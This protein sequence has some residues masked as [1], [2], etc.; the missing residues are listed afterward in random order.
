MDENIEF[1]LPEDLSGLTD[2]ALE[3]LR[4]D[5]TACFTRL[6]EAEATNKVV[7]AMTDLAVSI[8]KIKAEQTARSTEIAENEARQ[9]K[10]VAEVNGESDE[11]VEGDEVDGEPEGDEDDEDDDEVEDGDGDE[12]VTASATRRRHDPVD[13]LP[14]VRKIN[15]SLSEIRKRQPQ[16]EVPGVESDSLTVTASADIPQVAAGSRIED[17]PS[18]ANAIYQ[19]AKGLPITTGNE[20]YVPVATVHNQ[21]E[22]VV[23]ERTPPQD[24]EAMFRRISDPEVLLAAGG[25]CAP[26]EIRYSFFDMLCDDGM[27]D[28]PTFGVNRGGIRFP[29]SPTLADVYTGTFTN[30]TNPW[31]WTESDDQSA[32]GDPPGATKPCVRVPCPTFDERRLECYGICLTAGNLTDN[33]YP[34]ATQNQIRLLRSAHFHAMNAR[35]ISTMESLTGTI[36]T[37]GAGS[38]GA[39]G[40]TA[41][42][43][44]GY[45]EWAAIDIRNRFGLCDDDVLEVVAPSWGRAVIRQDLARKNGV[46]L[47]EVSDAQINNFFDVRRVRVQWVKDWQVRGTNQ[48][49]GATP[50]LEYPTSLDFM[51]YPAG[52]FGLGNGMTLEL[53]V[54]RDSILNS[55]NDHTAL[56]TEECHLIAKFGPVARR[57]RHTICAGGK[58]GPAVDFGCL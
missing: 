1:E 15:L 9:R 14:K 38:F 7:A 30:A 32:T 35:Y 39:T 42:D 53:G 2:E 3:E 52:T 57:Y 22:N 16:V 17:L 11:P 50:T 41:S 54:V 31:L 13:D 25:W 47:Y 12:P 55:T 58:A 33:A 28:L 23:G 27:I 51:I 10:L 45:T 49:G 20:Q 34:E 24:I 40:S 19:R 6:G 4:V 43:L 48:P 44:P 8:N 5:A 21:Y 18:L 26:S 56:W 29:V 36:I 46:E 37:G